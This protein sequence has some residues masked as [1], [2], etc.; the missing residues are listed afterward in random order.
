M[1]SPFGT[2]DLEYCL[3]TE[4]IDEHGCLFPVKSLVKFI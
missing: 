2:G 4:A 3:L 1:Q